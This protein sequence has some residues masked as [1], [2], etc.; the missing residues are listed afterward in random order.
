ML[1][2]H[3]RGLLKPGYTNGYNSVIREELV[4]QALAQEVEAQGLMTQAQVS[5]SMLEVLRPD[6]RSRAVRS[7]MDNL[8][9]GTSLLRQEPYARIVRSVKAH[10]IEANIAAFDV[11]QSTDIFSKLRDNLKKD[12]EDGRTL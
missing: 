6:A 12:E 10:S 7:A 8:A 2:A 9:M 1:M 5:A 11:L 4:L 3:L